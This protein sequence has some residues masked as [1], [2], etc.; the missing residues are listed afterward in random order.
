MFHDE[1]QAIPRK[2][3]SRAFPPIKT[4][5]TRSKASNPISSTRES[6]VGLSLDQ[7]L[8]SIGAISKR[9]VEIAAKELQ[10]SLR[11]NQRRGSGS[12]ASVSLVNNGLMESI[13]GVFLPASPVVPRRTSSFK[14]L[15][16]KAM[17]SNKTSPSFRKS[18]DYTSRRTRFSGGG[19]NRGTKASKVLNAAESRHAKSSFE[20]DHERFAPSSEQDSKRCAP[21]S[22]TFTISGQSCITAV[23]DRRPDFHL[24][25]LDIHERPT[26]P[27]EDLPLTANEETS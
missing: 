4:L 18:E 6:A 22:D 1:L 27:V 13:R 26:L 25:P 20:A 9:E 24:P 10:I 16:K 17:H 2:L 7:Y 15:V 11:H 21:I 5:T 8:L 14:K 12:I 23:S 19:S 3:Q